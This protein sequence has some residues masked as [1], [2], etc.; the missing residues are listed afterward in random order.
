VDDEL[1]RK[2]RW[3]G[4]DE[5]IYELEAAPKVRHVGVLLFGKGECFRRVKWAT[6]NGYC[7]RSSVQVLKGK[8]RNTTCKK[9]LCTNN[10]SNISCSE[11]GD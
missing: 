11:D 7:L 4:E 9:E 2:R 8:R 3:F 1:E 6:A 5:F 10:F